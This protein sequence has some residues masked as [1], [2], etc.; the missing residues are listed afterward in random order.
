[1]T[2]LHIEHPITDYGV[3]KKAFDSF[4]ALRH[5]AGV[6]GHRIQRPL[7][8]DHYVVIDLDF[9]TAEAAAAFLVQLRSRVWANP[10][11]SPALAG[12]PVTRILAT[13]EQTGPA[14]M[15]PP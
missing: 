14:V 15:S 5:E 1:M 13:E 10:A 3:W 7:D 9:D 11:N 8:D 6:R 4:A 2:I 12:T